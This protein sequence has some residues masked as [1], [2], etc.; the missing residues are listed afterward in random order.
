MALVH[1]LSVVLSIALLSVLVRYCDR[2]V[3]TTGERV[4]YIGERTIL[5]I[6]ECGELGNGMAGKVSGTGVLF[7]DGE[8]SLA[9]WINI[10]GCEFVVLSSQLVE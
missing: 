8:N 1:G 6:G 7:E 10:D 2:T 9:T 4:R 3:H 5:G